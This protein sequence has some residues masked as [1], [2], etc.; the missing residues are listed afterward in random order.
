MTF[1]EFIDAATERL[2][3]VQGRIAQRQE[4]SSDGARGGSP[5]RAPGPVPLPVRPPRQ[6]PHAGAGAG[7]F[8]PNSPGTWRAL[9]TREPPDTALE[10][11]LEIVTELLGRSAPAAEGRESGLGSRAREDG[12]IAPMS[13]SPRQPASL[14]QS[15]RG[16]ARRG[17]GLAHALRREDGERGKGALLRVHPDGEEIFCR[18]AY[19]DAEGVLAHL[20]NVGALLE[21]MLTLS[22]LTRLEIHGPAEE[23]ARLR[24]PLAHLPVQWFEVVRRLVR[25]GSA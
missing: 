24:A 15:A 21:E 2:K 19:R 17:R 1:A 20:T 13:L 12:R 10:T 6:H 25:P 7:S 11:A 14:F 16:P 5:S 4:F 23:L 22:E 3:A 9:E 18:E 8:V